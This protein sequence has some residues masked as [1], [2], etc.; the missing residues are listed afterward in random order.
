MKLINVEENIGIAKYKQIILSIEKGLTDGVLKKGDRLP[1]INRIRAKFTLSRDTVLMAYSEL[2][3]RGIVQSIPGKGYYIK[4]ENVDVVQKI[5]L[6]FDELNVFKEDLYNSFL[7]NLPPNVQVDI[8]FHHFNYDVFS[9]LI[10]DN[11]GNYNSYIIMP[12]NLKDTKTVI[13]KLPSE[14]VYILDQSNE[15][16]SEYQSIYQNFE[17]DIFDNLTKNKGLLN[18]YKKLIFLFQEYKQPQGMPVGFNKFC[19][20][21]NFDNE[22]I[23]SLENINLSKG[24]VYV[25]PDDRN[26][27]EIIQKIKKS[28][29]IIG[30]DIG[31]IAYNDS[32][33]KEIVEG[34]ITT[35]TTDFKHMGTQLAE[36]VTNKEYLIIE[37]PSSLI[38]RNSL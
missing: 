24:E 31:V 12:A 21:N 15:E 17:K 9:K 2:K 34:G 10:Y 20:M 1:S 28:K 18:K 25:I 19:K 7:K 16:L 33:L 22:I 38:I 32:L 13:E 4:S 8:Y 29:L 11:I 23:D 35:I 14:K 3:T 26:L 37:N 5:F 30:K 6:L 36:M 27:I